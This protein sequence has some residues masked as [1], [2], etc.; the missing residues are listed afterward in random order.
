M[1]CREEGSEGTGRFPRQTRPL[2]EGC[3]WGKPGFPHAT[4]PEAGEAA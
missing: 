1:K 2:K 3:P 4:E